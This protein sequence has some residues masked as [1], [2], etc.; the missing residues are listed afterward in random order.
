M[1]TI[2]PVVSGIIIILGI[3]I[4]LAFIREGYIP[5]TRGDKLFFDVFVPCIAIIAMII[6]LTLA[7]PVRE[8]M[9][10]TSTTL[11]IGMPSIIRWMT[12]TF[13]PFMRRMISPFFRRYT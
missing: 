10:F 5:F 12:A 1:K 7:I 4:L 9:M 6:Q 8:K 13:G 11:L 3:L 2:I